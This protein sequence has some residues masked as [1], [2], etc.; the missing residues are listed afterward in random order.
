M[1]ELKEFIMPSLV[2]EVRTIFATLSLYEQ[3]FFFKVVVG[4]ES[5]SY[6]LV[7]SNHETVR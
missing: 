6:K 3:I 1:K 4:Q 5:F 2:N 7:I